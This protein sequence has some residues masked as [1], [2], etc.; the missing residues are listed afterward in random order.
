MYRKLEVTTCNRKLTY[1]Q[2]PEY[3]ALMKRLLHE[4]EERRYDLMVNPRPSIESYNPRF[5][6]AGSSQL[7]P[8]GA[9]GEPDEVTYADV[10]RQMTLIINVLVSIICCSIAIWIAA[11]RWDVP[12]R[13]GLSMSGSGLVAVAEVAIYM[14][15]I[16]RV[17]EAKGKEVKKMETKKVMETWVLDG[18]MATS[19]AETSDGVRFRKGKHR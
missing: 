16:K 19:K 18:S 2:T 8:F 12:H 6:G 5:P 7:G 14:G 3:K 11:R 9:E 13:L 4:E 1:L 15:Y 17:K 10:N